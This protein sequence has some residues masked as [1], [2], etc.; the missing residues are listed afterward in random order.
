MTYLHFF[1][2]KIYRMMNG[3]KSMGFGR[4][5]DLKTFEVFLV[6]SIRETSFLLQIPTKDTSVHVEESSPVLCLASMRP[7]GLGLE[8]LTV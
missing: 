5:I 4:K 8:V 6:R 1:M 3:L 2:R 7:D